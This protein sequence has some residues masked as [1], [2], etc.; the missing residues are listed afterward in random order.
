[1]GQDIYHLASPFKLQSG[2]T[3][4]FPGDYFLDPACI[5]EAAWPEG[6]VA[7]SIDGLGAIAL[8]GE[9]EHPVD[10]LSFVCNDQTYHIPVFK[11]RRFKHTIRVQA[12][13]L[14]AKE[15]FVF[16]SFNAWDRGATPMEL[17][18]GFWE[19][20]LEVNP[21][22][23]E[24]LL[25]VDGKEMRDPENPQV[26][27]NG[28]GGFNSYLKLKM[29]NRL[30]PL[31][32]V[33]HTNKKIE[34]EALPD[35]Q[36]VMVFWQNRLVESVE[37]T[38]QGIIITI[39]KE[40]ITME[41]SFI[42]IYTFDDVQRGRELLIPLHQGLVLRNSDLLGPQDW[43][44][45]VMYSVM[46][47]R[48]FN[49]NPDNDA[50]LMDS[51]VHEKANFY[52]G[53]VAGIQQ[54]IDEDFFDNLGINIIWLSPVTE[55]P[56][57][58]WGLWDKGGV[59]TRFSGYH[60]YWPVSNIR[61]D[62]RFGNEQELRQMLNA[63]HSKQI[64]V[65][66]DY[67]ANHVH[68]EHP[69]YQQHPDWATD[70]YLPDGT[71]NTERWDDH[72]LTTWFDTFMPTLDLRR[73]EVVNPMTDSALIWLSDYEFDGFRHDATKHIDELFWRTLTGKIKKTLVAQNSRRIYQIG[74]TYGS[75]ELIDGYI[76][77]GMLD[78]QFDFNL[79]DALVAT[80]LNDTLGFNRVAEVLE[81]S[82]EVYGAHHLMGNISGNHDRPR[83]ISL[84]G[85]QVKPDEDAKLAGW[86]REIRKP[87]SDK[88]YRKLALLH[89]INF[90]IPGIPTIYYGDEYGV[91]GANDPDNRRWMQ[92]D[93]YDVNE[94]NLLTMV[95]TLVRLR[96]QEPAWI[97]GTTEVVLEQDGQK[98]TI[99][100]RYFDEEIYTVLYLNP[101]AK[102]EKLTLT[103]TQL[104]GY[105]FSDGK[106]ISKNKKT[107][108]HFKSS[109]GDILI[110]K[111]KP[112]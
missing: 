18:N 46:T 16:G 73:R 107:Q 96:R 76:S 78:A 110:Y 22:N 112:N 31:K 38:S 21:V 8:E 77:S 88:A 36:K 65:I 11:N 95:K 44:A 66:L 7:G 87:D 103:T 69:V 80:L 37:K 30:K 60:G 102:K 49:G 53:D 79:Y 81:N 27:D 111:I 67:V 54:K 74:E 23:Y 50:P 104:L 25:L 3:L 58:A 24:Y 15:V 72:R 56:Q 94:Q 47:D 51:T 75:P 26:V 61:P 2:Q 41:R 28:S 20:T 9:I 29:P 108:I 90:S 92:F 42:R 40:A 100:R 82:L 10:V 45:G 89:A 35:E 17:L 57:G 5:E 85:G 14:K 48:F 84:A 6:L 43:E 64:N 91:P 83:F 12:Q 33:S 1:M 62:K 39:P 70:L 68:Q 55:N 71:L 13:L 99:K 93:G 4:F 105:W 52:G 109:P 98:I 97:Y 101:K 63:A 106:R 34:L 32:A 59:T 86:T 19:A